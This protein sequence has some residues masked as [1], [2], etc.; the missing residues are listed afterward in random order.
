VTSTEAG[1]E[2]RSASEFED[3]V[4]SWIEQVV[5]DPPATIRRMAGGNRRQAWVVTIMRGRSEQLLFL[6]FDP[7]DP[8]AVGDPYTLQREAAVCRTVAPHLPVPK[9]LASH[10]RWQA[11][12]TE[13]TTGASAYYRIE[14]ERQKVAVASAF[15][16]HLAE[17]HTI[18]VGQDHPA[19]FA[20]RGSAQ[21]FVF[22]EIYRWD[23]MYRHTK[24]RDPM[25][26]F[27]LR[28]LRENVPSGA[29]PIV[30]VHGDAG[31][32][33]FLFDG[34]EIT[35]IIDW[36]FA[37]LGD[38]MEDIAWLSLRC[39]QEPFP[40]F[41]SRL[42]QYEQ[43]S[44]YAIDVSRV[45]FHRVFAELRVLIIR[46]RAVADMSPNGD[47]GNGLLSAALHRRLFVES[48]GDVMGWTGEPVAP[49]MSARV[50]KEDWLYEAA[51][52]QLQ[53]IA[54]TAMEPVVQSRTKGVVRVVKHLRSMA[55]LGE[56]AD[57][58]ERRDLSSL[59]GCA[60]SDCGEARA[61]LAAL[62]ESREID[63]RLVL[64]Y[65]SRWSARETQLMRDA[66]GGLAERHHPPLQ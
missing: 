5:G 50:L 3:R 53:E 28:W 17:L 9:V 31:P 33:N 45:K 37:H 7:A 26:E 36:E 12:L 14:L 18:H 54:S 60:V 38:P 13:Y 29:I 65:F 44:G 48:L 40:E 49:V 64:E 56:E 23:A 10:E 6:R 47:V 51:L 11:V 4:G 41:P 57:I 63:A 46:H 27:G 21:D 55:R 58:E 1:L 39:A 15:M 16:T 20:T 34:D 30:L 8:S 66:M 61:A 43:R 22:A 62:V 42:R 2:L 32:G 25:I 59:L 19:S 24:R 35:A 52:A